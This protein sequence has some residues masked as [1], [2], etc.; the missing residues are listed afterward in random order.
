MITLSDKVRDQI[1]ATLLDTDG[2]RRFQAT[3]ALNTK[4]S[5]TGASVFAGVDPATKAKRRAVGKRAKA[6]RKAARG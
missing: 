6:A 5:R 2:Y 3:R 1:A 4:S